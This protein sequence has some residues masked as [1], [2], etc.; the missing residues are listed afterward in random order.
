MM[1]DD[2]QKTAGSSIADGNVEASLE[3]AGEDAD[4]DVNHRPSSS[5][6]SQPGEYQHD[7]VALHT[8]TAPE[9]EHDADDLHTLEEELD[10]ITMLAPTL[11][12]PS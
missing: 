8:E 7:D 9:S 10:K 6:A 1:K 2:D 11:Y 4:A 3:N 12:V 5:G